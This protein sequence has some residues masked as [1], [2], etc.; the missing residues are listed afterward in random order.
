MGFLRRPAAPWKEARDISVNHAVVEKAGNISVVFYE[1]AWSDLGSWNAE[2]RE[3]LTD[4]SSVVLSGG[5]TA[6]DCPD[7]LLRSETEGLE[8]VGISLQNIMAV[9]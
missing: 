2:W 9:R 8:V 6:I 3:S 5:A 7:T 4:C 1:S